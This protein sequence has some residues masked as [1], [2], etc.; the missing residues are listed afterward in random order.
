LGLDDALDVWGVHG[1]GGF[2][3]TVLIGVLADPEVNGV[4]ASLEQFAKQL[5]AACLTAVYSFVVGYALIKLLGL[6][7]RILPNEE[8]Y[9]HGLDRSWHGN[10]A[11]KGDLESPQAKTNGWVGNE[12]KIVPNGEPNSPYTDLVVQGKS[13]T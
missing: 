7:M 1:M 12:V 5:A 11:Y 2:L 4:E 10:M 9:K 8:E 3:G 13:L 6:C